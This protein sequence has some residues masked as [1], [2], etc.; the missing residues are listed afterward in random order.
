MTSGRIV[1][2]ED[3][4]DDEALTILA[5]RKNHIDNPIEV[6]RDGAAGIALVTTGS[7]PSLAL[8]DLKLPKLSGFEVSRRIRANPRTA[9]V[10]VVFLT[11]SS[12]PED[13][14]NAYLS[15]GSGYVRKPLGLAEFVEGMGHLTAFW[16]KL[17]EPCPE[18]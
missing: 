7:V 11:S 14:A 13:I 9:L 4:P 18:V 8:M 3:E 17:N 2:V 15:G 12:Q 1:I 16:L 6:A 10:P 5:I